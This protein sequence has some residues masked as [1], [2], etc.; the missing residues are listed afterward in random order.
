LC[1]AKGASAASVAGSASYAAATARSAAELL[2]FGS[3]PFLLPLPMRANR[4]T[5]VGRE[6]ERK[7]SGY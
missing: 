1:T 6:R 4:E 3:E 5:T 2:A 7:C